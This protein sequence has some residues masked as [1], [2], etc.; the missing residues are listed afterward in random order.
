M[1]FYK[2]ERY[3]DVEYKKKTAQYLGIISNLNIARQVPTDNYDFAILEKYGS[4]DNSI[5]PI[6]LNLN[7]SILSAF[8]FLPDEK[9]K[10][11]RTRFMEILKEE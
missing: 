8:Y 2:L 5:F 9:S 6:F 3:E 1:N 10:K 7:G 11:V 4:L